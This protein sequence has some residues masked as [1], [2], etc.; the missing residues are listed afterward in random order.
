MA[1]LWTRVG[2]AWA[3]AAAILALAALSIY[4]AALHAHLDV[5]PLKRQPPDI[6]M[7]VIWLTAGML[8]SV[9]AIVVPLVVRKR[10]Q[11]R[12]QR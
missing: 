12:L 3:L 8:L 9:A 4:T 7:S 10:A 2:F 6:A 5:P 1:P 11:S